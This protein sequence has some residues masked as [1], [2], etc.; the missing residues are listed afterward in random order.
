MRETG[1]RYYNLNGIN[2]DANPGTYHFKAGVA[3]KRGMDVHYI[4]RF[5]AH[6]GPI[7]ALMARGADA[8]L[9]F[10]K[11]MASALGKR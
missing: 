8:L 9:P 7:M 2:P 1:C 6:S 3:G 10:V 4:G 11:K 5:D